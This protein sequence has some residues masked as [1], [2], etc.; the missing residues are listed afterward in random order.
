MNQFPKDI[1]D[2]STFTYLFSPNLQMYLDF[3]MNDESFVIYQ[4]EGCIPYRII[5]KT[6]LN[7][8]QYQLIARKFMW[9]DN[10]RARIVNNEG[11]E[12]VFHV[13]AGL[14]ELSY[15]RVPML[16]FEDFIT[17]KS[18]SVG[19][20]FF[21]HSE[22]TISDTSKRLRI[23]YQ[24][25]FRAYYVDNKRSPEEIYDVLFRV[26]YKQEK[27]MLDMSF[28]YFHW[29][30]AELLSDT[31]KK[32]S[33]KKFNP[34]EIKLLLLNIFPRANTVIHMS[35]KNLKIIKKFYQI[36]NEQNKDEN[37]FEVPFIN[38]LEG[39]TPLHLCLKKE[40]YKSADLIL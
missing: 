11:I 7:A 32:V 37:F 29:K 22:T 31:R 35:T 2:F 3:D 38:N 20:Y 9:V 17:D 40:N 14:M 34:Q 12:K 27:P 10:F 30:L 16:A 8:K 39:E 23:K 26:D 21:D 15:G 28:T 25:Y 18:T 4:T 13:H 19:H 6:L 1:S 5:P 36:I 24:D 33:F